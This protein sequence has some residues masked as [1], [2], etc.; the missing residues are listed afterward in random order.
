MMTPRDRWLALFAGKALDRVPCDYWGTAEVT[1]RLRQELGC[2]SE[3]ALWERLGIDK[4]VLLGP[5]HPFAKED[6]W[7]MQS[8]WSI[9][10]IEVTNISYGE[11]LGTYEEAVSHPLAEAQTAADVERFDWPDP[12]LF[13]VDG[14]RAQCEAWHGY[15]ILGGCYEPFYLYCRLRGMEQAL[16][17]LARKPRRGRSRF[18]TDLSHSR[19]GH[20]PHPGVGPRADRFHLRRRR[21]GHTGD[22]ADEPGLFP[23]LPEALDAQDDRPCALLRRQ[24]DAPR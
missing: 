3:R 21:P 13:D 15:P 18:G 6:T 17:D 20:W 22:A 16:A 2:A 10:H 19:I 1:D 23:P 8:L 7:H 5:T 12:A 14:M 9:W 24:G 4:L 11:G